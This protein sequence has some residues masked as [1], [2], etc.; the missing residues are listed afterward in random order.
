[1]EIQKNWEIHKIEEI[2]N[3]DKLEDNE[4]YVLKTYLKSLKKEVKGK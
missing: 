2:L 4:R 3:K 1:M